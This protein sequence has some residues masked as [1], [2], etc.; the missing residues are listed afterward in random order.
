[1]RTDPVGNNDKLGIIKSCYIAKKGTKYGRDIQQHS[2]K[3]ERPVL[4]ARQR[5]HFC[6]YY[7]QSRRG[8]GVLRSWNLVTWLKYGGIVSP[9]HNYVGTTGEEGRGR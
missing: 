5:K 4:L 7:Q 8:N 6:K 3:Y 9:S 1:M 2:C